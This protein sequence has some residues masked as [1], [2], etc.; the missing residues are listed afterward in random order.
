V[1]DD[2][3][4]ADI[5]AK[6]RLACARPSSKAA[7]K[8][9]NLGRCHGCASSCSIV[10]NLGTAEEE[11]MTTTASRSSEPTAEGQAW[12]EEVR[13]LAAERNAVILAHNYQLPEIQDVA[14]HV[15]DSLELCRLAA[16]SDAST[17]VLC[18]VRFMAET[19]KILL[20]DTTVLLPA[21]GA[22]CSLADAITAEDVRRWRQE[23]PDALAVAYVNTTAQVKAEVDICCTSANAVDVVNSL[24]PERDVLFLPDQFLGEHVRRMTGRENLHVWM[25]ECHV[26][27]A[28]S[29]PDLVQRMRE[30][31]DTE[32][33]VHPECG[34]TTSILW[35]AGTGDLPEDRVRVLSTGGMIRHARQTTSRSV[36]VA[37]ETGMLH[38][39]RK[40][41]PA[42]RF[43]AVDDSASCRYMKMVTPDAL[44]RCLRSGEE[45]ITVGAGVADRARRA[46]EAMLAVGH[47]P[48]SLPV[49]TSEGEE[50]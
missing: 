46:I 32:L 19:A 15:G 4:H 35:L 17:V 27:A 24:P 45:S 11:R 14:D 36:L 9:R 25:G 1:F 29:P 2:G 8:E 26:H 12:S 43:R 44:L 16:G 48:G 40:A 41:N 39:L 33:L 38:Q 28:I 50:Q 34:C 31:S 6:E 42:V 7:E 47:T 22:G 49:T 13:R 21:S 10:K 3:F 18:G 30:E 37:T 20:P 23:H 5:L